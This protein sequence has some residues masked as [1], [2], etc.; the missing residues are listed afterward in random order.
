M[1]L[2][3]KEI[4][5]IKSQTFKIFGESQIYLFGSRV[6]DDKK[7]GDIDLFII[8]KNKKDSFQKKLLL[9]ARLEDRL[10]KPVDIVVAKDKDRP[11]EKEARKGVLI[12]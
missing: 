5:I 12:A 2:T 10:F 11:I 7:G 9:K 8:P 1:R 4:E 6:D 3:D